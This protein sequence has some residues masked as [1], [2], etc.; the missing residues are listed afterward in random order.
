MQFDIGTIDP[1]VVDGETLASLLNQ[2]R[3]ALH[4]LHRGS[5]RPA[6]AVPGMLWIN[7]SAGPAAW[8][9]NAYMG[10][11]IGDRPLFQFDTTTGAVVQVA[12][13]YTA[14]LLNAQG[15]ANPATQWSATGNAADQRTWR[16]VLLPSGVLQVQALRGRV[17]GRYR[18]QS[19]RHVARGG[20]GYD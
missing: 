7:D 9:V 13:Q 14:A 19:Q 11:A 18:L 20:A 17:A 8:V 3:D 15:A 1:F 12:D 6:Y 16:A 10:P 4:S 5:V 2:W